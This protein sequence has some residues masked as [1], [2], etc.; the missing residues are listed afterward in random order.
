MLSPIKPRNKVKIKK[1][2]VLDAYFAT[3]KTKKEYET[4]PIVHIVGKTSK[5]SSL[6]SIA[7]AYKGISWKDIQKENKMKQTHNYG[8]YLKL[9]FLV[10]KM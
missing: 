9:D 3:E 10:Y 1:Q 7:K 8:H 6:S 2:K 4:K 5:A